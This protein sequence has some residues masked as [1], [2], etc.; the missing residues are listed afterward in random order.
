MVQE[1]EKIES[2]LGN[3]KVAKVLI[4]GNYCHDVL[5]QDDKIIGE[6]LGGASSFIS[7]VFDNLSIHS[8]YISKV[9]FDF[10]YY[11]SVTHKPISSSS[12]MTTLFHAYFSSD[13]N[14]ERTLRR[15]HAC[16]PI[17]V[18]DLPNSRFDFGLAVGVGGEILPETL[19]HM[20]D[21]CDVVFVDIQALIRVFDSVDGTVKLVSL[22]ESG[23]F[24][25]LP[26]IGF[27]KASAEEALFVDIEEA[28][29]YC[30]VVV[31]DGKDGCRVYTKED[32]LQISPFAAVQIDP[33]GAGDSFLGGLV[34]GLIQGLPVSDAALLGNFFGSLT[35]GQIGIPKFDSRLMQ[36]VKDELHQRRIVCIDHCERQDMEPELNK[37]TAENRCF[38]E[39][40]NSITERLPAYNSEEENPLVSR[41]S[42][43]KAMEKNN[44]YH[45]NSHHKLT[46]VPVY[47]DAASVVES[48][49]P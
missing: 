37:S 34:A 38:Q 31:T 33:T 45:I 2:E 8:D 24:H 17:S 42:P 18:S 13:G 11:N 49:L 10:A 48:Q 36:I 29:K 35:V 32:R 4:V 7:N 14:Q 23:F 1:V 9:G 25:L 40:L 19:Q 28:R 30:C 46:L 43:A 20:I 47:K 41:H 22:K 16:D 3:G 39:F 15:I 12:S 6:S 26:K 5:I 44:Q 21:I 27:L